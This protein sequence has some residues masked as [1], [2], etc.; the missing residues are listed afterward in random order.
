[1]SFDVNFP[2]TDDGSLELKWLFYIKF[3]SLDYFVF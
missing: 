2:R 1:M 3:F